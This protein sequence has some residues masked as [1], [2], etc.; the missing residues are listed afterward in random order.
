MNPIPDL[1]ELAVRR[2]ASPAGVRRSRHLG[3]RVVLPGVVLLGFLAVVA[4]AARDR[5]LP[6]LPVTVVPVVTTHIE[7]QT[8]GTPLFQSAGWVEPR[9][10][11][12]LVTA[13]TEGVV[14]R[15]FVVEGQSIKAG[16]VVAQLIQEDA[17]LALQIV[18]ADRDMRQ[19]EMEQARAALATT[20][21]ALPSQL[22]AARSR[23]SLLQQLFDSRTKL[24]Q[25]GA[26]PLYSV[27]TARSERDAAASKVVELEIRQGA[28]KGEKIRPFAE[29]EANVKSTAARL[30]QAEAAVATARLRLERTVIRAPITGQVLALIARPGQR[31]MGQTPLGHQ[32]A[33]TI[34]T[35]FDPTSLQVRAD[36]RLEDVPKVLSGQKVLIDAPVTPDRPLDGEVLQITSQAD[37][38]KNTL[39]VKVAVKAPPPT[40][41]PDML[42]QVTF[43]ARPNHEPIDAD[44][45]SLRVLIPKQLVDSAEGNSFVWTADLAARVALKKSIKLGRASGE[46]VEVVQGLN[47]SDRLIFDGRQ[48]LTD[49]Q[50]LSITHADAPAYSVRDGGARPS[51][52][53]NPAANK[54]HSGKQ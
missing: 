13:L 38:Q 6:A 17:R 51:R 5:L 2:P 35:M 21:A 49:G 48:S 9:P 25:E 53:P 12:T 44:K 32:E 42:V 29:L 16:E 3:T 47:A 54:G 24:L 22:E 8:E 39:Q 20:R 45:A 19:A 18:E 46:F 33:S 36:V 1:R 31:L 34:I 10:T 40:L 4:W 15:L 28:F 26:T 43:L 41:R 37:I 27:P 50:R 23:L 30:N 52:L 7:L 11:P 14:D